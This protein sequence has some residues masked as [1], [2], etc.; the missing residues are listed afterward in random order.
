M[1]VPNLISSKECKELVYSK[2]GTSTEIIDD[3]FRLWAA[4]AMMIIGSP[5]SFIPKVIGS[6]SNPSYKFTNHTVNLPCDFYALMPGGLMVNGVPVRYSENA[7]LYLKEGDC[8]NLE[9]LNTPLEVFTDNFGNTFSPEVGRK[10]NEN[11]VD[12]TFNIVNGQ[13]VFNKKE[14]D[15][16]MAYYSLPI[17]NEGYIMI[18]DTAKYKRAITDYIIHNMDYIAWRRGD[19]NNNVYQESKSNKE[20]SISAASMELKIPDVAQTES[21]KNA[22]VRLVPAVNEYNKLFSTLGT[23]ERRRNFNRRF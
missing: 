11:S 6:K 9:I 20:W 19:I 2:T 17:D 3:D 14:G 8:C 22:L 21:I 12:I 10:V 5:V 1:Q 4:E 16:C 7:F 13:I 23:Q 18:P 15:V